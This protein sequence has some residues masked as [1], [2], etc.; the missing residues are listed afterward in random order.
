MRTGS[1]YLLRF[2]RFSEMPH[3]DSTA[4]LVATP[5][6]SCAIRNTESLPV[7]DMDNLL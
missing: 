2:L 6:T 3:Y 7:L 5:P 4:I 1:T